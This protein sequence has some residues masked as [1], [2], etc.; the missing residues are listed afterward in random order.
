MNENFGN[1]PPLS[2]LFGILQFCTHHPHFSTHFHFSTTIHHDAN[3]VGKTT[4]VSFFTSNVW[5]LWILLL[6]PNLLSC[7]SLKPVYFFPGKL[8]FACFCFVGHGVWEVAT[9]T[10]MTEDDDEK[11]LKQCIRGRKL[12]GRWICWSFYFRRLLTISSSLFC[13]FFFFHGIFAGKISTMASM[14]KMG[15]WA[16]ERGR[17]KGGEWRWKLWLLFA[18]WAEGEKK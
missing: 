14:V 10:M 13:F 18:G 12:W 11:K 1:T 8:F 17:Y 4:P 15:Q 3:A 5:L 9:M 7:L 16:E 6:P 2:P